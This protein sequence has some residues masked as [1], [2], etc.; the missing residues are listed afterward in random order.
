M[1]G[2]IGKRRS[3]ANGS[4]AP[5]IRYDRAMHAFDEWFDRVYP[6]AQPP[7]TRETALIAWNA[8][9][10]ASQ[11]VITETMQKLISQA[12]YEFAAIA[13]DLREELATVIRNVAIDQLPM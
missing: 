12:R 1:P 5:T 8:G 11:A 13:R 2:I 4:R 9:V 6:G 10:H 7:G 3:L